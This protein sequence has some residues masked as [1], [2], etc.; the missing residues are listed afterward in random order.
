M[1]EVERVSRHYA[2]SQGIAKIIF[3]THVTI[4]IFLYDTLI[5]FIITVL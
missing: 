1:E 2:V 4:V 5:T 3:K